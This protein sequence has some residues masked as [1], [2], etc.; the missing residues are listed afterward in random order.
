MRLTA[1]LLTGIVE[2]DDKFGYHLLTRLGISYDPVRLGLFNTTQAELIRRLLVGIE[3]AVS[4]RRENSRP[5]AKIERTTRPMANLRAPRIRRVQYDRS[6]RE[7][8]HSPTTL[9]TRR[10]TRRAQIGRRLG[11][12]C[13]SGLSNTAAW[14]GRLKQAELSSWTT[15][16]G[17]VLTS[18]GRTAHATLWSRSN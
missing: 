10:R 1:L 3:V 5:E 11:C 2:V 7:S 8:R 14:T 17:P 4:G 13:P 12:R 6:R 18:P 16:S 9:E 15:R